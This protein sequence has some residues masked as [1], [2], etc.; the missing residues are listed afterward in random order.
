MTR[1]CKT[2]PLTFVQN[3]NSKVR[4]DTILAWY[5]QTLLRHSYTQSAVHVKSA[6]HPPFGE[7]SLSFRDGQPNLDRR[8]S[9]D[10]VEPRLEAGELVEILE[11]GELVTSNPVTPP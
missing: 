2:P 4:G 10:L 6:I 5:L 7:R 9:L 1:C 11:P 3:L 8:P